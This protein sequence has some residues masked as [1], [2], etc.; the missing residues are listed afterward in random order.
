MIVRPGTILAEPQSQ[1]TLEA[2]PKGKY[3]VL[4]DLTTHPGLSVEWSGPAG[5][6][7]DAD[8]NP[9]TVTVPDAEGTSFEL[10]ATRDRPAKGR[11]PV[12]IS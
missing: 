9:V 4:I 6:L 7:A 5:V 8:A 3:G 2:V 1:F 10:V 12:S 11:S